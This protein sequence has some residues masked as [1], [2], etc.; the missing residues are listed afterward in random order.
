MC[1]AAALIA[2][3]TSAVSRDTKVLLVDS[4]ARGSAGNLPSRRRAR[5]ARAR[6]ATPGSAARWGWDDCALRLA[7]ETRQ[8][9]HVEEAVAVPLLVTA[10]I[11][12]RDQAA[13]D[14]ARG[15]ALH[16]SAE[17]RLE[18]VGELEHV[19]DTETV[20][21]RVVAAV[22]CGALSV[23]ASDAPAIATTK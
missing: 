10:A 4:V 13:H 6:L 19:A 8:Q 23:G 9:A 14:N 11:A 3:K 2:L 1:S 5:R 18:L 16:D 17:Q 15:E 7:A 22:P 20:E 21:A 12:D